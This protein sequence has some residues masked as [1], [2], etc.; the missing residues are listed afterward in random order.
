MKIKFSN[1]IIIVLIVASLILAGNLIFKHLRLE[2]NLYNENIITFTN[3]LIK[4]NKSLEDIENLEVDKEIKESLINYYNSNF[5]DEEDLILVFEN[6]S[7]L[8]SL[9]IKASEISNGCY[10]DGKFDAFMYEVNSKPEGLKLG[11]TNE[12]SYTFIEKELE[13]RDEYF[14]LLLYNP[15]NVN[16]NNYI[17]KDN[18]MYIRVSDMY[19]DNGFCNIVY[20]G[21]D[22][23]VVRDTLDKKIISECNSD[24][25]F[26]SYSENSRYEKDDY[27]TVVFKNYVSMNIVVD[28]EVKFGKISN[29]IFK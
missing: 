26:Q 5:Y 22:L 18:N 21:F 13:L 3:E 19:F 1:V 17:I 12:D 8:D 28:Y 11:Y 15:E 10:V 6:V 16:T 4:G 24:K 14:T 23:S 29:I 27:L 2:N 7:Y 20:K 9:Y 25:A